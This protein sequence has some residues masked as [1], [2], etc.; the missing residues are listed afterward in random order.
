MKPLEL[1]FTV[2]CAPDFAFDTWARNTSRWWPKDHTVSAHP[3]LSVIIEPR[4]GGRIY[5]RTPAGVEHDWGE[6]VRW[7]PPLPADLFVAHRSRPE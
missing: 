5:E 6:V 2:S 3:E 4:D 1:E 7:E